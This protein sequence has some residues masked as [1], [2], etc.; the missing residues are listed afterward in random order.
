MNLILRAYNSLKFRHNQFNRKRKEEKLKRLRFKHKGIMDKVK[1]NDFSIIS[2][3][4]WG[5]SVY[6]DLKI[7]YL[8][9]TIGLFFYAP[10]FIKMLNN[11]KHYMNE[12]PIFI[13]QSKYEEA[14]EYRNDNYKYPIGLLGGDV[15]IQ[16]LH[17]KSEEEA[18]TKWEERKKRIN[19]DNLYIACTDR[20]LMTLELMK[21]FDALDYPNK[22]IFTAK[23][24]AKIQSA[25]KLQSYKNDM[26]VGDLYN[27]RYNVT[28][29]FNI[30]EWLK[31]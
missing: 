4:C 13:S 7:P 19:W 1:A 2:S 30:S 17:Y 8:T 26:E 20:D 31:K 12:T 3:N 23:K 24:Y 10:C 16:F 22:V 9:P 21:E 11:L 27:Q 28:K 14:N 6:E 29:D 18:L 25:V 15:E 5:G